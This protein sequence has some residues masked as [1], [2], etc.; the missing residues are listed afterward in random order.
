M[1]PIFLTHQKA[2]V[3]LCNYF[4]RV[5]FFFIYDVYTKLRDLHGIC[6]S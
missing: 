5:Y 3:L 6:K 2:I 4:A 1:K